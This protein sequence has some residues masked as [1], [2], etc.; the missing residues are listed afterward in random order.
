MSHTSQA[1][2][3]AG[4]TLGQH[5]HICALFHTADEEYRVLL[6]F[7]REGIDRGE[8]A[9]HVVD[10]GLRDQHMSRLRGVGI[11]TETDMKRGRLVVRP[12]NEVYLQDGHFNQER[13]LVMLESVLR[14]GQSE[15]YPITR[16]VAHAEFA[17]EDMPGVNDLVE[18]ETRLNHILP[19]Y[20]DPV[21]CVYDCARFNA[22]LVMDI[23][24][25]HPLV[26]IGGVL[27]QNPFFIPPDRF[28][29]ELSQRGAY[30]HRTSP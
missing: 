25:T 15:G 27:Q 7:I 2:H 24:R 18:Y 4:A 5:R 6:P 3:F 17:L 20:K 16:I 30:R 29:N 11:D 10:P 13:M 19:K 28:L 1:V 26:I 14:A 8:R 23:M 21:V 9:F 12:W 22:G